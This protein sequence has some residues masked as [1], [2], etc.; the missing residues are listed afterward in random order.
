MTLETAYN[1][2]TEVQK[3][4][5]KELQ[6][7]YQKQKTFRN[8]NTYELLEAT[9]IQRLNIVNNEIE[10]LSNLLLLNY[11]KTYGGYENVYSKLYNNLQHHFSR[12]IEKWFENRI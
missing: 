12:P 2:I 6:E 3:D 7:I 10:Y 4:T 9:Y 1:R 8:L 5:L 11:D